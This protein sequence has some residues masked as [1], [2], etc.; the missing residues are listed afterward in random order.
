MSNDRELRRARK[1]PRPLQPEERAAL[2]ALL[3]YA[4]FDGRDALLDQ[5]DTARVVGFCG[6]G[7]ATVE[8]AVDAAPSATSVAHPIPNEAVVLDEDGDAIGGVL[9][10]VREGYLASLEVYDFNGVP[11]SPLPSTDRLRLEQLGRRDPVDRRDL[12]G[13][14]T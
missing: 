7:C 11:I 14:A 4:D 13:Q 6:C 12:P 3:N 5:V 8:I 2:L 10:F 9:V 1:S